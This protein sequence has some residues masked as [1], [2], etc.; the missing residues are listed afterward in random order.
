MKIDWEF[1][2]QTFFDQLPKREQDQVARSVDFV[3]KNWEAALMRAQLKALQAPDKNTGNQLYSLRAGSD[4]RV[5]MF[6]RENSI[7]VV[8]VV[9]Q[10][11]IERLR[12]IRR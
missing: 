3:A 8:D 11:Q 1:T 2:A 4:L 7:V 6:R 9:R 10:S 5:L 12:S